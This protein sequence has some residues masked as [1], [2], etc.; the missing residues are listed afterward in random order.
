MLTFNFIKRD[1]V[2][3]FK[4]KILKR[5]VKMGHDENIGGE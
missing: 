3:N 5:N 4:K 1:I 2:I